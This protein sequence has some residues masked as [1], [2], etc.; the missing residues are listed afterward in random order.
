MY[1]LIQLSENDFYVDCPSK[2]GVVYLGENRAVL[3]DSGSDKDA[4][5]KVLRHLESRGWTLAAIYNTHSHADHIGGNKLLQDRTGCP[6]YAP[7][8]ECVFTNSPALEPMNLY[9]GN[10]FK[11]LYN[12]FLCAQTSMAQPLTP[13]ALPE[14]LEMV[15]LPGHSFDMVGYLTKDGNLFLA[16][17]VSSAETL[18]KYGLSYLWDV[19]AFLQTLEKIKTL[20]A[21]KYIPAHA[22]VCE[23][24]ASLAAL[25]DLNRAAVEKAEALLCSL[26]ETP[27]C[28]EELLAEVF[29][30]Y[31]M[32]MNAQQYVLIG[33]TVRSYLSALLTAGRMEF[34]FENNKMLWKSRETGASDEK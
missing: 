22:P 34:F 33:S 32:T 7:G 5:K 13:E 23:D 24:A 9:G 17:C 16:D 21:K 8:M 25:A 15:T 3:I 4:G 12:K 28:F 27:K 20:P 19:P 2:I 6:I 30:A 26:C 29:D 1:E 10:P 18:E 11:D 14:G 31:G